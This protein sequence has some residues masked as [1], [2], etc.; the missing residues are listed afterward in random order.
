MSRESEIAGRTDLDV[1]SGGKAQETR[2]LRQFTLERELSGS[3]VRAQVTFLDQG[4]FVLLAGGQRSHVGTVSLAQ[5][6]QVQSRAVYPG[7]K[8]QIISDRW[9][10]EISREMDTCVTV[11][12]GIHYD[13]ADRELI[14]AVIDLS[15]EL[16]GQALQFVK[17]GD[18]QSSVRSGDTK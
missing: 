3:V 6:G 5:N 14:Q 7:H 18:R 8:E 11:A 12:C 4:I 1:L 13:N 16:L 17:R 2:P 15:E 10:A 9:A